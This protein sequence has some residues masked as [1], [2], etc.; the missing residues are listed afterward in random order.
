VNCY[1]PIITMRIDYSEP[2][3]AQLH[4]T[5]LPRKWLTLIGCLLLTV[6]LH[7]I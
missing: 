3:H 2:P 4:I 7:N 6:Q 5:L 1:A